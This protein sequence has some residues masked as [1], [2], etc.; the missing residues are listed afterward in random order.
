MSRQNHRLHKRL[1]CINIF[2]LQIFRFINNQRCTRMYVCLS[3]RTLCPGGGQQARLM[4]PNPSTPGLPSSLSSY[5]FTSPGGASPPSCPRKAQL[6]SPGREWTGAI[7]SI[8]EKSCSWRGRDFLSGR[9]SWALSQSDFPVHEDEELRKVRAVCFRHPL[10]TGRDGPE[11]CEVRIRDVAGRG[12][13]GRG[14]QSV[15]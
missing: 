6:R 8:L 3:E 7:P 5:L 2:K 10:R 9:G 12:V 4:P 13:L 14:A 15:P 11:R 1:F